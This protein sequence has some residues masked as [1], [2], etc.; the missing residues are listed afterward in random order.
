MKKEVGELKEKIEKLKKEH[1]KEIATLN[2]D[3]IAWKKQLASHHRDSDQRDKEIVRK[4][5]DKILGRK[6]DVF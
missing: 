6:P 3:H 5:K 4:N 1:R 2:D